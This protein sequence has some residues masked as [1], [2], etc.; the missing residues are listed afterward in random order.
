MNDTPPLLRP[1]LDTAE[2]A[3]L[4]PER[5]ASALSLAA[6][7]HRIDELLAAAG[8]SDTNAELVRA[9]GLLWHDHLEASHTISQGIHSV[10]GSYVHGIMHRREPDFGNAAY[11]FRRVGEHAVYPALAKAVGAFDGAS[12]FQAE[13]TRGNRWNPLALIDA[14]EAVAVEADDAGDAEFLR[15]V[16]AVEFRLLL[17]RFCS[18]SC[19]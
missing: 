3:P 14:C 8:V 7:N 5:R 15:R 1:L 2:P 17:A 18:L 12:R 11:W 4:G 6:T 13:L 16:Q 19:E 9:L 10:D